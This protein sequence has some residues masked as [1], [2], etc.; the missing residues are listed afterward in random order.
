[1]LVFGD[2][3]QEPSAAM[4]FRPGFTSAYRQ[5]TLGFLTEGKM[6]SGVIL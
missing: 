3:M 5:N 6:L 4:S 1:M 2:A